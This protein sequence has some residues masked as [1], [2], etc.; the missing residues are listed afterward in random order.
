MEKIQ[1]TGTEDSD[2]AGPQYPSIKKPLRARPLFFYKKNLAA[3][4]A[5]WGGGAKE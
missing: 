2:D 4:Y 1:S 5:Y 3:G